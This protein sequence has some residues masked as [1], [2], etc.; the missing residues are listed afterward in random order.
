MLNAC[1]TYVEH[2]MFTFM[3]C[4]LANFGVKLTLSR[5]NVIIR[6]KWMLYRKNAHHFVSD[7][8]WLIITLA[9]SGKF[10]VSCSFSVLPLCTTETYPTV[11]RN[12]GYGASSFC[13]RIGGILAPYISLLVC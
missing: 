6:L 2:I 12:V 8:T 1:H 10:F 9:M 11:V 4:M 13:A 7:M 3:N 5:N